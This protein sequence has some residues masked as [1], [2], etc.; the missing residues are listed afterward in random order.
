MYYQEN[1]TNSFN[2]ERNI[3][4]SDN[5]RN[6]GLDTDPICIEESLD[7]PITNILYMPRSQYEATYKEQGYEAVEFG[8]EI[9]VLATSNAKGEPI[10]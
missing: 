8:D 9:N 2:V 5:K 1:Q 7:C 3:A 4:C 10:T 6:C